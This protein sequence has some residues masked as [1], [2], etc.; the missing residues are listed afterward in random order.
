MLKVGMKLPDFPNTSYTTTVVKREETVDNIG[1]Y[2]SPP[3]PLI[4]GRKR[5]QSYFN[6]I[7][8][9]KLHYLIIDY[10]GTRYIGVSYQRN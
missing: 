7:I 1:I 10:T 6:K 9:K 2:I 5:V 3:I 8:P 4:E